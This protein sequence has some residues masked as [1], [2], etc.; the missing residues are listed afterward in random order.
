MKGS[1]RGLFFSKSRPRG[2]RWNRA[3]AVGDI[4][5]RLDL[6]EILLERIEADIRARPRRK[7]SIVFLGDLIDRGPSS[8]GVV[9]R[10]R[11]FRPGFAKTVF[12]MGNHEEVLLRILGGEASLIPSWLRFGGAE[13]LASYG[14]DGGELARATDAQ[15]L[16]MVRRAIPED[17][18]AFI[19]TFA[20]TV[21]FGD[22][23]FVHA[24]IRPG[25]ELSEQSKTDLRWIRDPFLEDQTERDYVVVHGHTIRADVEITGNRIG[26]DTGAFYTGVLTA[27]AIDGND[28]WFVQTGVKKVGSEPLSP[29]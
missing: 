12:L 28:R 10:L 26:I 29:T 25:V 9:E 16:A 19:S 23:L 8:A 5:G 22:Y 17:H 3:Y 13:T 24:G 2:P 1:R 4:H 11:T 20:D 27:L 7:T 18:S 14:L 15:A 21:S 6:L